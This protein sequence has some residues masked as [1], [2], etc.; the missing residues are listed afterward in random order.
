M[1]QTSSSTLTHVAAG[2]ARVLQLFKR[3]AEKCASS[4]EEERFFLSCIDL[5][6][7]LDAYEVAPEGW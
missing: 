2:G 7:A 3:A 4:S 6:I 5:V 1:L